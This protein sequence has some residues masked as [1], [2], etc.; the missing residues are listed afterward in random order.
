MVWIY[1][2]GFREGL[3]NSTFYGPDFLIDENVVVVAMNYR[4]GPLGIHFFSSIIFNFIKKTHNNF[5]LRIF[6]VK[7]SQRDWKYGSERS[8]YGKDEYLSKYH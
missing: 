3:I 1:G 8:R 7:P 4:L 6:V 2:G 5:L